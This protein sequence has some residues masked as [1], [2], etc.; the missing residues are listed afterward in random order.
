MLWFSADALW[1]GSHSAD[2]EEPAFIAR[3][4]ARGGQRT[5]VE[6]S[7][8]LFLAVSQ[9]GRRVLTRSWGSQLRLVEPSTGEVLF[10]Q[11]FDPHSEQA[12]I[13]AAFSPDGRR[14]AVGLGSGEIVLYE[15]LLR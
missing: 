1:F 6:T 9:D 5:R 15:L 12:P 4:P 2:E 7:S 3:I 10:E 8:G 14:V 11:P 13:S